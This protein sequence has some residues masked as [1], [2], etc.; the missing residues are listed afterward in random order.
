M[1]VLDAESLIRWMLSYHPED[2]PTLE[3]I[4]KH[5]WMNSTTG[6]SS[7]S[8]S[9]S[10]GS[11][12][13]KP[14]PS[15]KLPT[16]TSSLTS[17]SSSSGS[18]QFKSWSSSS[19]S[20]SGGSTSSYHKTPTSYIHSSNSSSQ[21]RKT[22]ATHQSSRQALKNDA[23]HSSRPAT[24]AMQTRSRS[25]Q[26]LQQQQLNSR[27]RQYC[28]GSPAPP[29]SSYCYSSSSWG[30]ATTSGKG[31]GCRNGYSRAHWGVSTSHCGKHEDVWI[32]HEVPRP[33]SIVPT[34]KGQYHYNHGSSQVN[35][36]K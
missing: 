31:D 30:G 16:G 13:S 10:S 1:F 8:S 9:S 7:S 18:F 29:P 21:L 33:P 17:S 6:S 26:Q 20:S 22:V 14:R 5:P 24:H 2:R 15:N 19:L 12:H 34:R 11:S 28:H 27:D 4:F 3:Q 25:Q 35:R 32:G 23:I 36:K